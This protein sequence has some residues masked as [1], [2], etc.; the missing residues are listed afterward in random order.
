MQT[1]DKA[2]LLCFWPR[3]LKPARFTKP[4]FGDDEPV[5]SL[6]LYLTHLPETKSWLE[7]CVC[8]FVP[9]FFGGMDFDLDLFTD[10]RL[11]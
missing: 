10:S 8:F 7:R 1:L 2:G 6:G 5:Y 3:T 11:P 4:E 9:S